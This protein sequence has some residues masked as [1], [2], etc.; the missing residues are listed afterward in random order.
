MEIFA[1]RIAGVL[2]MLA[3]SV[4]NLKPAN[5]VFTAGGCHS[6]RSYSWSRTTPSFVGIFMRNQKYISYGVFVPS[7]FIILDDSTIGLYA[8]WQ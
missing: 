2:V 8:Y 5:I 4:M 3:E 1:D 7:D 6:A